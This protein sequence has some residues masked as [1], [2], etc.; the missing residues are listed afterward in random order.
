MHTPTTQ[1]GE[2]PDVN[3]F[4]CAYS[5]G[6]GKTDGKLEKKNSSYSTSC[7]RAVGGVGVDGGTPKLKGED[8]RVFYYSADARQG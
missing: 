6:G 4:I 1:A 5:K 8:G 7:M 2:R 3:N